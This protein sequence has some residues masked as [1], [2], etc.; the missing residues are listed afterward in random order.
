MNIRPNLFDIFSNN[1]DKEWKMATL[2]SR[3]APNYSIN[4]HGE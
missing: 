2:L 3:K 1:V 4:E